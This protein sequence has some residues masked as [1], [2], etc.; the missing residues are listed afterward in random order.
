MFCFNQYGDIERALLRNGNVRSADS[1]QSLLKPVVNRYQG[2]DILRFFRGDA[3]FADPGVYSYPEAE[4]YSYA[5]R[6]KGN[7]ILQDKVD[8]LLTRPVGRPPKK[9]IVLY[10]SFRY[11]AASWDKPRRVVAKVEW[12]AKMGVIGCGFLKLL[13]PVIVVFPGLVAFKLF[14]TRLDRDG[15]YL[16]MIDDFL[17]SAGQGILLAALIAAMM[18]TVSSVLNSA[19]TIWIVDVHK[20]L[21][22]HKAT[23]QEM[24]KVGKW[25]TFII[26]VFA[27]AAAPLLLK[28]KGG[29]FV[30]VQNLGSHFATPISVIFLVAFLWR[31]AHGR[32]A[33]CTLIFGIAFGFVL[34]YFVELVEKGWLPPIKPEHVEWMAPFMTRAGISWVVSLIALILAS[35]L[36]RRNPAEAPDPDCI[37]NR[38]W[39]KLPEA[40]RA[41]NKGARNLMFWWAVMITVSIAI[42]ALF[43]LTPQKF[44]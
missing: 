25:A 17:P 10:H 9:P 39:G 31:K 2:Y 21:L 7:P 24:V 41:I 22:R 30:Y 42:F 33:T 5:I 43:S 34:K 16:R 32:A 11:Q 40:E 35:C 4:G 36:I 28:Y 44:L 15:V 6:L 14:G 19:S 13:V 23:E 3:A 27:T 8:H 29:I 26:I 37:W 1:W 20:R 12:D 38:R 18:S